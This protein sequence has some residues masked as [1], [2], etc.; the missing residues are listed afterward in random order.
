MPHY[1]Y[2]YPDGGGESICLDHARQAFH[3]GSCEAFVIAG[4]TTKAE[5]RKERREEHSSE[6]KPG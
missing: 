2:F 4:K 5:E 3:C 6:A 1:L